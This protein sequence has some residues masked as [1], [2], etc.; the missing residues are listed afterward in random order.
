MKIAM[1]V[2]NDM[3]ADARVDREARSL[4][5]IG[6][7]IDVFA[8]RRPDLPEREDVGP[9]VIHRVADF[10][11]AGLRK[12]LSKLR[13]RRVRERSI[14]A[15]AAAVSPDVVHCHDT[16]TLG[17]GVSV[18]RQLGVPYVY[19]AHELYP[20]SLTQRRFQGSAPVQMYLRSQERQLVP[21][22]AAVITVSDG[23]SRVLHERYGVAP[24]LVA[25]CPPLRPP[26]DRTA[27]KRELGL[28]PESL[29]VLYQGGL[30]PGRAIDELVDAM[31]QVPDA[32]LVVQGSGEYESAM[33]S[34]VAERGVDARTI[35]MGQVP[36]ERLFELTCGADVGTIFLDGVT[37]N[38]QL[39][40]TNRMFMYMMAGIPTAATDLP[41]ASGV[42]LPA[43]AGLV[44]P[45]G[46]AEAMADI[47]RKLVSDPERRARMG[48]AGRAAAES[49]YN[50]A[51]QERRLLDVYERLGV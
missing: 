41:G 46:D 42:L 22:A 2:L 37:L 28:P 1:L 5:A 40:W 44:A 43:G 50:W 34:R 35:F 39:A 32:Y 8:L 51:S 11:R 7:R 24:V 38:H 30:L 25:N 21:G 14:A 45:A 9:Y 23:L 27:L 13:E 33:R 49:E 20:D 15:H 16:N 29:V 3:T 18:A 4:A 48:A 36:H 6:H 17:I 31:A 10:T 26:A 12:P 19:D 47:L